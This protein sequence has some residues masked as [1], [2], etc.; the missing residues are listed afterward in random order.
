MERLKSQPLY[1]LK[2]HPRERLYQPNQACIMIT[3]MIATPLP[4]FLAP[5]L[6]LKSNPGGLR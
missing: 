5:S 1:S 3:R 6:V 2:R 4:L